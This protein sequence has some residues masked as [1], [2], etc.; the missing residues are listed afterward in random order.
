MNKIIKVFSIISITLMFI[1]MININISYADYKPYQFPTKEELDSGITI[2]NDSEEND[3]QPY[4]FPN[5]EELRN[6]ITLPNKEHSG[7]PVIDAVNTIMNIANQVINT[8]TNTSGINPDDYKPSDPTTDDAVEVVAKIGIVLGF[9]RN[10]SAIVSVIVL[11]IIGFKYM[12]GSVEQKANYKASMMPY[13]IGC[14]MA[15]AGTTL[16][17]F[18]YNMIH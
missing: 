14:I 16:V 8:S 2:P 7:N 17:S 1:N 3:D 6:E 15:V 18:I 10:I 9:I 13:I 4:Q 11:M 5:K 12:I